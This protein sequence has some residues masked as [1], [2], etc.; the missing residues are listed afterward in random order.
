M[1]FPEGRTEAH[2]KRTSR[3][4]DAAA[5]RVNCSAEGEDGWSSARG[6]SGQGATDVDQVVGDDAQADPALDALGPFVTGSVQPVAPLQEADPALA[7]GSP[8]L[9]MAEP[10]LLLQLLA[11]GA[12][13]TEVG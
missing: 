12:L 10:A 13:G 11:L 6:R 5:W 1:T 7:S 9:G 3:R 8:L 2:R 4:D